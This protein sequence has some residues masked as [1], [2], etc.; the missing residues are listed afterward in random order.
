MRSNILYVAQEHPMKNWGLMSD[1]CNSNVAA[2]EPL[3]MEREH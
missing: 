1:D 2:R 3:E